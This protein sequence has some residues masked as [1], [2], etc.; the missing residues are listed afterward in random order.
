VGTWN[1]RR[2]VIHDA[3]QKQLPEGCVSSRFD[4]V[5][6]EKLRTEVAGA[7]V[8]FA[9][10]YYT[11]KSFPSYMRMV[12][13][14]SQGVPVVLEAGDG[15]APDPFADLAVRLGGVTLVRAAFASST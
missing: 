10:S 4:G 12:Q 7:A 6:G 14:V 13:G 9:A 5:V 11:G 2:G 3:L 1:L 15:D 8:V